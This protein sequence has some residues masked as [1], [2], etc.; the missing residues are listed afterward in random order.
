MSLLVVGGDR[1]GKIRENLKERGFD[2]IMHVT[3]RKKSEKLYTIPENTDMVLVLTD[4]VNH[5][6]YK[7]IK[8]QVK[9]AETKILY[10]KRSWIYIDETLNSMK[11]L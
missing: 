1:L 9:S 3:G 10:S 4:F 7:A 5:Q 2:K 11:N 6:M 8:K